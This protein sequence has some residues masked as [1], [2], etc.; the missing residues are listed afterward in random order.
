MS[1]MGTLPASLGPVTELVGR[2]L[3][4]AMLR[5]RLRDPLVRLVTV[6]GRAGVG[7]SRLVLEVMREIG[8]EF[9]RVQILDAAA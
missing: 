1:A 5:E 6:T 8:G 3:E 2:E 9:G 7:K 4:T